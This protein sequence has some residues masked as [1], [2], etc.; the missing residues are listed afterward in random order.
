VKRS[1]SYKKENVSEQG[2]ATSVLN[3]TFSSTA[4]DNSIETQSVTLALQL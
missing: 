1:A 3:M 2:V 4:E